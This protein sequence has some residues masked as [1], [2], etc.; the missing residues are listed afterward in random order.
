MGLGSGIWDPRSGIRDSEKTYFESGISDPGVKKALDPGSR[1][2]IRQAKNVRYCRSDM[3][4]VDHETHAC[5]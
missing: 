1:I 2:R 5:T 3:P 4:A